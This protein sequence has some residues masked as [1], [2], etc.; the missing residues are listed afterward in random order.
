MKKAIKAI[1][2][3]LVVALVMAF[4]IV[5]SSEWFVSLAL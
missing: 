4:L 5:V 2:D 3:F 1:R